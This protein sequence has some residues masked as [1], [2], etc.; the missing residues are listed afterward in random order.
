MFAVYKYEISATDDFTLDLPVGARFLSVQ[1]QYGT[2][3]LYALVLPTNARQTRRF[4]LA[5]T[6]HPIAN[7]SELDFV[8]T[9][10]VSGGSLVFHLFVH[11]LY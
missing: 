7:P 11:K 5:G 6:G 1:V 10:M 3:V 2:P 9:F 4:R 8:G